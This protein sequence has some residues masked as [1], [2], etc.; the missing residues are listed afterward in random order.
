[1]IIDLNL[2][3]KQVLIVGGGIESSRKVEA[4]LS[5]QCNITVV[6]EKSE[7]ETINLVDGTM[8]IETDGKKSEMSLAVKVKDEYT[9]EELNISFSLSDETTSTDV[10]IEEPTDAKNFEEVVAQMM[11]GMM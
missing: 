5:Q 10:K 2:K 4:L 9:D 6:A 8:S 11:G 7:N 3:G 1:M